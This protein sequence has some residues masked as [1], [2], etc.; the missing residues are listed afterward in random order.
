MK[1]IATYALDKLTKLGADKASVKITSGRKDEFNVEASTFSL[2]RTLFE[3]ALNLKAIIG[4]KKGTIAVNKLDMD[5]VDKAVEECITMA[6]SA[7]PDPA[8]DIA[9]LV[10]NKSFSRTIGGADMGKLF[11]R[12]KEILEDVKREYPNIS[13]DL[14]TLYQEEKTIYLNSNGVEFTDEAEGYYVQTLFTAKE[15]EAASSMNYYGMTLDSLDKPFL[16]LG[17][18]RTLIDEA[19]RSI[20]TRMVD[21]KFVGKI[22]VTPGCDDMIWY[23]IFSCFLSF[24]SILEGTS[25]WKDSL[26]KQVADKKLTMS[27]VP[28]NPKVIGG[29]RFTDDGFI[30]RDFDYIKDGVLKSFALPL[31]AANKTGHPRAENTAY[32]NLEVAAGDVALQDMIKGIDKGLL[33]NRFSGGMPGPSGDV[34]GVAKNSFLIEN[35]KITDAVSETMVSFNVI[36]ILQ[37]I[38]AISRERVE[39]GS[40]IVPWCCFDGVTVSGK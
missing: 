18:T 14:M 5:S 7:T 37:N 16:D 8:E 32:F 15:G 26:G 36:D 10:E 23:T 1:D 33:I 3:D 25:R 12:S 20:K 2:M 24:G 29:E 17:M 39:T 35:G 6:N 31:Y 40:T 22:I 9:P 28:L 4:G 21:D 13:L 34:S 38:P 30:S 11:S 27:A 19:S